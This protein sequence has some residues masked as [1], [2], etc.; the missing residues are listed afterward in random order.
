MMHYIRFAGYTAHSDARL[1]GHQ[2]ARHLTNYLY[3]LV[4]IPVWISPPI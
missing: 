1:R 4:T 2:R 3:T